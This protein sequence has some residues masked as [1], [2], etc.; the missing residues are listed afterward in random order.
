MSEKT[1]NTA[2]PC[3]RGRNY[4]LPPEG[5][6]GKVAQLIDRASY[7]VVHAP[8]QCGKTTSF[9]A[10][11][12]RL[13]AEGRYTALWASCEA[14]QASGED[15]EKAVEV[16]VQTLFATARHL[17]A[18]LQP[19][20]LSQFDDVDRLLL[21]GAFL[22]AWAER[23]PR[24]LVLFLDEIDALLGASL[25]SVLRQLRAS[26]HNRPRL[27]PHSVA[28]IGLRDVR[29]YRLEATRDAPQLGTSSPFNIKVESIT[30]PDF[31]AAEVWSLCRQ[32]QE[33]TGQIFEEAA[34]ARIFEL[35]QGQPRLVNA[36]ARQL[37]EVDVPDRREPIQREHVEK[38]K[39]RLILR[40]DTHLDSL[41][42]RLQEPRLRRVIAPILEGTLFDAEVSPDDLQY[43]IDL[44]L[45]R[46]Q[47]GNL[48]V[49]NPIYREVIPRAL[50]IVIEASMSVTRPAFLDEIGRLRLDKL[51]SGF[52]AFWREN[53]ETYLAQSPYS[54]AAAQLVFM[55]YLHK[56]VNGGGFIDREYAVGSGRIDLCLRWPHPAGLQRFAFE[57][58]VRRNQREIKSQGL[59][60]L[61]SYLE[62]L[63][64]DEGT[65]VI[66]D[67]RP[68]APSIVRRSDEE[69]VEHH[70]RQIRVLTL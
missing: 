29:D 30:L 35:T 48:V 51:L 36:L 59:D 38:A 66:F 24:P 45:L 61:A 10:L 8:R 17:P 7:F 19:P 14:A 46:R 18:E 21:L 5:R 37:V 34:L 47:D 52:Q 22:E 44:G 33:A 2:G 53:A 69:F 12:S 27:F 15:A 58:K 67:N 40:Q 63:G 4:M 39:E 1:F 6:L 11:A 60:Q 49:A 65:L 28:L 32:H 25:I 16:V 3:D 57:L 23:S 26:F 70:G 9:R 43:A 20:P 56:V 68:E 13:T 62:R 31:T 55:A 41:T 64:L 50:A 54:E 42:A